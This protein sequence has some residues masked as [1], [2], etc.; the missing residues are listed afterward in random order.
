M[1]RTFR[2]SKK[3]VNEINEKNKKNHIGIKWLE[4]KKIVW[5]LF[6]LNPSYPKVGI[7][8]KCL[9]IFIANS[10]TNSSLTRETACSWTLT[11]F[12]KITKTDLRTEIQP[13]LQ[14]EIK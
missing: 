6:W 3:K 4:K 8:K 1:T 5:L 2:L 11:L 9:L 14:R 7:W 10:R 12:H 13:F